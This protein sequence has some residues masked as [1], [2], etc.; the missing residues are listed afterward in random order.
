MVCTDDKDSDQSLDI[1]RVFL[2]KR[3]RQGLEYFRKKCR[4][5]IWLFFIETTVTIVGGVDKVNSKHAL[6]YFWSM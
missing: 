1:F 5:K 6:F 3:K 2:T 4:A